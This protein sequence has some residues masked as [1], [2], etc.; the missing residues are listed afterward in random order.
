MYFLNLHQVYS[1]QHSGPVRS[2][3]RNYGKYSSNLKKTVPLEMTTKLAC[4]LGWIEPAYLNQNYAVPLFL[5]IQANV[6][7]LMP[8]IICILYP[9][10]SGRV[11][12]GKPGILSFFQ[13]GQW[14]IPNTTY[15]CNSQEQFVQK[16]SFYIQ[17]NNHQELP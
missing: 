1:S 12:V 8:G 2:T 15:I 3:H 14:R 5:I 11:G 16:S 7:C 13:I 6:R 9:R 4:F 17:L 10:R